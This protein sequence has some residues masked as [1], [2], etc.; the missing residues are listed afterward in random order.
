MI[1]FFHSADLDGHCG[2][3]IVKHKYPNSDLVGINYG[4][5][6]PWDSIN[7]RDIIITDYSFSM[8][9]M[10]KINNIANS[11]TWIDHHKTAIEDYNNSNL[12]LPG[13]RRIGIGACQLTW[14]YLFPEEEMPYFVKL[15]S[16]FDVWDHR[17]LPNP[18]G[19]GLR[20]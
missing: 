12:D 10:E 17:Q 6:I 11:L 15:L 5:S 13:L 19:L 3:A 9:N 16:Q 18:E 4:H 20:C 7:N 2:G 1:C 14:E 8:H